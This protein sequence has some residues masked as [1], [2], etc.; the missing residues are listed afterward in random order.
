[1]GL[2]EGRFLKAAR[3]D[4]ERPSTEDLLKGLFGSTSFEPFKNV[5]FNGSTFEIYHSKEEF[6][7]CCFFKA[8]ILRGDFEI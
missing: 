8:D 6:L 4:F 3:R 1:M 2:K 5:F 7:M